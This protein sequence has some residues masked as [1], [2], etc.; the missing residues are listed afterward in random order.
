[1]TSSQISPSYK[2]T[3]TLWI[4]CLCSPTPPPIRPPLSSQH[5][6]SLLPVPKLC[7]RHRTPP[8]APFPMS[9]AA[10]SPVRVTENEV[11]PDVHPAVDERV[12]LPRGQQCGALCRLLHERVSLKHAVRALGE[13]PAKQTCS[14][15]QTRVKDRCRRLRVHCA[16]RMC[17]IDQSLTCQTVTTPAAVFTLVTRVNVFDV[18]R[19]DVRNGLNHFVDVLHWVPC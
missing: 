12:P 14:S 7:T 13:R 2:I 3:H 11:L 10:P 16:A 9:T 5:P 8:G 1:M 19:V 18:V 4:I 17:C 6:S 15:S